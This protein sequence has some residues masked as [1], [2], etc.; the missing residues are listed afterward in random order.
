MLHAWAVIGTEGQDLQLWSVVECT[1]D[2]PGNV[3]LL[4]VATLRYT[5]AIP[6]H[7]AVHDAVLEAEG[8][9]DV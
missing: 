6:W 1:L 7:D 4:C 2:Q 3:F 9:T 8:R 5:F